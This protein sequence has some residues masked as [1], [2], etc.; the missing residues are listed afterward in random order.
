MVGDV[1]VLEA[2]GK[3]PQT[4]SVFEEAGSP[5]VS[6][7]ASPLLAQTLC[8]T[9]ADDQM[10]HVSSFTATHPGF[11]SWRRFDCTCSTLS[12]AGGIPGRLTVGHTCVKLPC[13][14]G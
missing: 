9:I 12:T 4:L 3:G 5:L 13:N 2:E 14:T 1:A 7:V 10:C 6:S 8:Q 11:A